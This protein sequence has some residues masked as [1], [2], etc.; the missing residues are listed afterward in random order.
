MGMCV[1]APGVARH[2]EL[3][4]CS[5]A[6]HRRQGPLWAFQ[7][8]NHDCTARTK[9]MG[10]PCGNA[11]LQPAVLAVT[12]GSAQ[13]GQVNPQHVEARAFL[14]MKICKLAITCRSGEALI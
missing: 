6:G 11:V 4:Q 2:L 10:D 5:D 12:T 8:S 14:D 3:R 1:A 13:R 9:G 7:T